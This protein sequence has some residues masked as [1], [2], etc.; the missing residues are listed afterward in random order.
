MSEIAAAISAF[1]NFV[2]A[3]AAIA[4]AVV[5]ANGLST[6]K[7]QGLW[8]RDT[9][10]AKNLFLKLRSRSDAFIE[11]RVRMVTSGEMVAALERSF[12]PFD[13]KEKDAAY[14]AAIN[15]RMIALQERRREMYPDV[16]EATAVWGGAIESLSK[17][18]AT[19]ETKVLFAHQDVSELS[20]N[21]HLPRSA[22]EQLKTD[23]SVAFGTKDDSTGTAYFE[24]VEKIEELLREKLHGGRT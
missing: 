24:L 19:L 3:F 17:Q 12:D 2:M 20:G 6:W 9:E 23:R 4:A 21:S 8:Q 14:L 18:L 5:A 15:K 7:K 22:S 10:L 11:L 1:G 16:V 13:P